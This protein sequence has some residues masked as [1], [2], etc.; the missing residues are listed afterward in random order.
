MKRKRIKAGDSAKIE[1]GMTVAIV[2][3]RSKVP[4]WVRWLLPRKVQLC[5]FNR[6]NELKAVEEVHIDTPF[7]TEYAG[8]ALPA[9][10]FSWAYRIV[11]VTGIVRAEKATNK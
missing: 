10:F 8:V 7:G 3:D 6:K 2:A 5:F 4:G 9:G 11:D 1:P